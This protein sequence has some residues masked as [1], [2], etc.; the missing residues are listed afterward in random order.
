MPPFLT[1]SLGAA[2]KAG[3]FSSPFWSA[4]IAPETCAESVAAANDGGE[5]ESESLEHRYSCEVGLILSGELSLPAR[6]AR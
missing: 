2:M 5:R 6:A 1:T 3:T 4:I